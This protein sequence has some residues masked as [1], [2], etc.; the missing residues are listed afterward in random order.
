MNMFL[1]KNYLLISWY[2]HNI[3]LFVF[4]EVDIIK[5]Y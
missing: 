4:S 5:H 1:K 3:S 2:I